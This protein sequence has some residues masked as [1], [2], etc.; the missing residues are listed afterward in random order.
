MTK[1]FIDLVR[2]HPVGHTTL[3]SQPWWEVAQG[4]RVHLGL[5]QY[6]CYAWNRYSGEVTNWSALI[7][8]LYPE[9][10]RGDWLRL[11]TDA[12]AHGRNPKP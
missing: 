11:V 5:D 2:S 10:T 9:T 8:Q 1:S 4:W 12:L 7:P 3:R 6:F